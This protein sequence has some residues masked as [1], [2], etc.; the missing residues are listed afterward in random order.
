MAK[1]DPIVM[2]EM[3]RLI[4]GNVLAIQGYLLRAFGLPR[5]KSNHVALRREHRMVRLDPQPSQNNVWLRS[6]ILAPDQRLLLLG[7]AV[8]DHTIELR[9]FVQVSQVRS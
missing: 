1:N 7:Q 6:P 3:D 9:I 2:L 8:L 5:R 4:P